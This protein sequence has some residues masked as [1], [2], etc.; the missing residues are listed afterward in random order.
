MRRHKYWLHIGLFLLTTVTVT[1]CGAIFAENFAH[2]RPAVQI[3]RNW[4]LLSDGISSWRWWLSGLPFSITLLAILL[5]HEV[6]H[7]WASV[8]YGL[9]VSLPYFLPFPSIIGTLGAFIRIRSPIYSKRVLFD[10]GIA[11][12]LA[13]FALVMPALII[14]LL[15]SKVIPGIER[16]GDLIFATPALFRLAEH[17]IFPGVSPQDIALHPI[18]RAAWVGI[19]TTAL[20][21]LPIGQL[22][23]GH[24]L[25]AALPQYHRWLS[26]VFVVALLPLGFL[27]WPWLLWAA[28]LFFFGMKHPAIY[29]DSELGPVRRKLCWLVILIFILCFMLAPIETTDTL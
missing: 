8:H 13:G 27:Y 4:S 7:Y 18:S 19:F 25:Y 9:D 29:D 14:G 11:G 21:L 24:I 26:R 28:F 12:P 15:Y 16:Q 3:E 17:L 6:G 1:A 23:G 5:A 20:N 2:N 10:V 22:D